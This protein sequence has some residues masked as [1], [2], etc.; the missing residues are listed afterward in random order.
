MYKIHFAN[1]KVEKD[2]RRYF[3]ERKDVQSK[4]M[5]LRE[6]PHSAAGAHPLKGELRGKWACWLGSNIRL[7]YS[8]NDA[9]RIIYFEAIGSHKIY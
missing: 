8:V 7:I 3:N 9:K 2:L 4:L 6:N 1:S 5:R